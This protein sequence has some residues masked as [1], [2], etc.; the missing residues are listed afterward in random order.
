MIH[1]GLQPMNPMAM[2]GW[3]M[4]LPMG[5][6]M[7]L[8]PP[9]AHPVAPGAPSVVGGS[10]AA[11]GSIGRTAQADESDSDVSV[12][13]R[14]GARKPAAADQAERIARMQVPAAPRTPPRP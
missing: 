13:A 14:R 5:L 1:G 12:G 6:P 9:P 7:G 10:T 8:G 4:T 2:A 11:R 3:P